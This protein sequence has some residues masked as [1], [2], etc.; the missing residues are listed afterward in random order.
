LELA[1]GS[2]G[3]RAENSV[4]AIE[5]KAETGKSLLQCADIIT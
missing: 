4:N 5:V 1:Q 2:I 3:L